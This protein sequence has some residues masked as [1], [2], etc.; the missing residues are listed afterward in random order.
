MRKVLKVLLATCV[1]GVFTVAAFA[2][3]FSVGVFTPKE[4]GTQRSVISVTAS[5]V[6]DTNEWATTESRLEAAASFT[7]L[8]QFNTYQKYGLSVGKYVNVGNPDGFLGIKV[9][10]GPGVYC[11]NID[12]NVNVDFGGFV[13]GRLRLTDNM[14]FQAVYTDIRNST[15]GDGWNFALAYKF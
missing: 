6:I 8:N 2:D 1:A 13:E 5:R 3:D 10:A 15:N 14:Y 12:E 11:T 7:Q 9:G 4:L